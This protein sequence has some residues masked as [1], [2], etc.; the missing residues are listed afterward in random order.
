V[1][2]TLFRPRFLRN[3]YSGGIAVYKCHATGLLPRVLDILERA[4]PATCDLSA[5]IIHDALLGAARN[6]HFVVERHLSPCSTRGVPMLAAALGKNN[7][8]KL[9]G[10]RCRHSSSC[11]T[12]P[13]HQHESPIVTSVCRLANVLA[14]QKT[15]W[16]TV[17]PTHLLNS[18]FAKL[19]GRSSTVWRSSTDPPGKQLAKLF[20]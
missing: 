19:F 9:L 6:F 13:L 5:V 17:W 15:V 11:A 12:F 7:I 18:P 2:A 20:G 1:R 10:R 8:P 4:K 16:P 14:K 3:K